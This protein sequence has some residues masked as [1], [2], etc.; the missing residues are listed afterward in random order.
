LKSH[1]LIVPKGGGVFVSVFRKQ[2]LGGEGGS[3][4]TVHLV[5]SQ[6][7]QFTLPVCIPA[8]ADRRKKTIVASCFYLYFS[9]HS[10]VELVL[11]VISGSKELL[12][13]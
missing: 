4:P 5:D 12:F 3:F 13:K 10:S 1:G 2:S 8:H 7:H 6:K 11:S 9:L